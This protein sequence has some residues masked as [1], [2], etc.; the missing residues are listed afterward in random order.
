MPLGPP[1]EL[2]RSHDQE[3]SLKAEV[4]PGGWSLPSPGLTALLL[5]DD[6]VQTV[7]VS[8]ALGAAGVVLWGDL[9]FSSSEVITEQSPCWGPGGRGK[10]WQAMEQEHQYIPPSQDKCWQLHDYLL[11]PLGP[12]VTNVTRAAMACSQQW[13]HGRGRCA[14]RD[15][16]QLEAFLHLQPDGS[17]GA[18]QSFSCHCY[19]G[20]AGQ[21]CG[22]PGPDPAPEEAA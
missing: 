4:G 10:P 15:P 8:A 3:S 7:G 1:L 16:G 5:Q 19:R 20:W 22:E 6:L 17:P 21:T 18:W 9:S 11:G 14:R 2:D 13:C 12:Y